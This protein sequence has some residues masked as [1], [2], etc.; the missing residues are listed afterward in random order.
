MPGDDASGGVASTGTVVHDGALTSWMRTG[1]AGS[2]AFRESARAECRPAPFGRSTSPVSAATRYVRTGHVGTAGAPLERALRCHHRD[3]S[4]RQ[5]S[6]EREPG[7]P[8][9]A[10][11]T[12]PPGGPSLFRGLLRHAGEP[13]GRATAGARDRRPAPRG[14]ARRAAGL[15]P[16]HRRAAR[17]VAR[18]PG[19]VPHD[20][21]RDHAGAARGQ[22]D[23]PDPATTTA[24]TS[25]PGR[26]SAT[27]S[28]PACRSSA[29]TRAGPARCCAP[30]GWSPATDVRGVRKHG[31]DRYDGVLE[32]AG[33][34]DR[35]ADPSRTRHRL[36]RGGHVRAARLDR[37]RRGVHHDPRDAR[38]DRAHQRRALRADRDP[39]RPARRAAG[40]I[41]PPEPRRAIEGIGRTVVEETRPDHRLPQRPGVR[42]RGGRRGPDRV[43][44]RRRRLRAGRLR[45]A[46][47][48]AGGG[49]HRLGR[50]ARQ[51]AAHRRRQPRRARVDDPGHGR[52]RRVDARRPDALRRGDRR[53]HHALEAGARPVRRRRPAAPHDPRRPG[54][55]RDRVGPPAGAHPGPRRR[56]APPARHERRAVREPRP[57]AGRQPDGRPPR[58]GDGRRRVRHQLLGPAGRPGRVAR[59][60][61][62]RA[63]R[64]DGAVLTT[65]RGYPGDAARPRA[66][67]AGDHRRRRS[68]APTAAE[69]ELLRPRRQPR[70][71]DAAAGGQGPVD[72][73][74]RAVLA[75]A[76]S[77]GTW[78]A[79]SWR[80]RWPTRRR[81]PSRTRGSTRT[82][83]T[84]P[85]A[86]CSPAS[87]TTGSCTNASARRSSARSGRAA[88]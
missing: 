12:T 30:A 26:A 54:R 55:H 1:T 48:Q 31:Y 67:G 86:T 18:P 15:R 77:P 37:R 23:H 17:R 83:A 44:G 81:W 76:R 65:S 20:R 60:L 22:H 45:A 53:G 9:S 52:R 62:G 5:E 70:P 71:R 84:A 78:S 10:G 39:G 4:V 73:P 64:D 75:D 36:A 49:V 41:G 82:P 66:P 74:R 58:P 47:L 69:V 61:P 63:G 13:P 42:A 8:G 7:V 21:R 33:E 14:R 88:R 16:G 29:A 38:R 19:P 27:R 51:A 34:L 59:L 50:A 85:T 35:P 2:A 56:A 72:R 32:F 46:P 25:P 57:A 24:S 80:G 40:G 11:S 6:D 43:R 3:V 79:S 28:R 87:T 68:R